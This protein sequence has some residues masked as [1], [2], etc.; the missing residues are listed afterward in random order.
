VND[1]PKT[2]NNVKEHLF[3]PNLNK[4]TVKITKIDGVIK[5]EPENFFDGFSR[6]SEALWIAEFEKNL[7]GKDVI[8]M[9]NFTQNENALNARGKKISHERKDFAVFTEDK[10]YQVYDKKLQYTEN[11]VKVKKIIEKKYQEALSTQLNGKTI[12]EFIN[13]I[14]AKKQSG[15]ETTAFEN[16]VSALI[17]STNKTSGLYTSCSKSSLPVGLRTKR[18]NKGHTNNGLNDTK[19][20]NYDGLAYTKKEKIGH[21]NLNQTITS[22][23]NEFFK[24]FTQGQVHFGIDVKTG[25]KAITRYLGLAGDTSR[26]W[27]KSINTGLHFTED[28]KYFLPYFQT[29]SKSKNIGNDGDVLLAIAGLGKLSPKVR[30]FEHQKE[31]IKGYKWDDYGLPYE[32]IY[33]D[34]S[35]EGR[36]EMDNTSKQ[37]AKAMSHKSALGQSGWDKDLHVLQQH[38]KL[39]ISNAARLTSYLCF[40]GEG[41][42]NPLNFY[43]QAPSDM[44][45]KLDNGATGLFDNT[46]TNQKILKAVFAESVDNFTPDQKKF[47]NEFCKAWFDMKAYMEQNHDSF[48]DLIRR[49]HR[50]HELPPIPDIKEIDIENNAHKNILIEAVE[51]FQKNEI[52]TG[53]YEPLASAKMS[54]P[55]ISR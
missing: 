20:S 12:E 36:F 38:S 49:R 19:D 26:R 5:C 17:Q 15:K 23:P 47:L 4:E 53:K 21:A 1:A 48:S 51:E 42:S 29:E 39:N 45:K 34:R 44:F 43:F 28:A 52:D 8:Y 24:D 16:M 14:A 50:S 22:K 46:R 33:V 54:F 30:T 41:D 31:D 37:F 11:L 55:S 10:N 2:E 18:G 7:A 27:I 40:A 3:E 25:D 9:H 13:E 35:G 32:L 6:K